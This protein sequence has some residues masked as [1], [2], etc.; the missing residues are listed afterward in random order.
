LQAAPVLVLNATELRTGS[1]FRFGTIESESWR[2]GKLHKNDVK[3]AHAV[4]AS[5]AFRVLRSVASN[6][7]SA[8][9]RVAGPTAYNFANEGSE[10]RRRWR[11]FGEARQAGTNNSTKY[12]IVLALPR[13]LEPLFSP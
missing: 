4:A 11:K 9:S 13:G 5:A 3:V 2:S 1:A 7:P 6:N 8:S 10:Q 12:L